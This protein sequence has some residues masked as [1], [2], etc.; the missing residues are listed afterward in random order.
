MF[1]CRPFAIDRPAASSEPE[2]IF[3]P[4][5]SWVSVFCRLAW[6]L[7]RASS[8]VRDEMLFRMVSTLL[9]LFFDGQPLRHGGPLFSW[10]SISL[11]PL[12]KIVT[13]GDTSSPD[14]LHSN[15]RSI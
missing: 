9:L 13:L 2:L 7:D 15:R 3:R 12:G 6:V 11:G 10:V 8:A 5:E 14:S 1:A 4:G